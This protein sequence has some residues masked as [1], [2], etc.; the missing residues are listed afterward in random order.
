MKPPPR[1]F[2]FKVL[3]STFPNVTSKTPDDVPLEQVLTD[4]RNG[5]HAEQVASAREIYRKEGKS[6][7]YSAAKKSLPAFAMSGTIARGEKATRVHSNVLQVDAD[8]LG[9]RLADLRERIEADPHVLFVF[10][11][12]SGD[13]LKIGLRVD[14]SL[15][16]E[17]WQAAADYFAATYSLK[18][19]PA[20]KNPRS[21]CFVSHDP[22]LTWRKLAYLFPLPKGDSPKG[23]VSKRE[24]TKGNPPL[25]MLRLGGVGGVGGVGA[26]SAEISDA[27]KGQIDQAVEIGAQTKSN[28]DA[29]FQAAIALVRLRHAEDLSDLTTPERN[30]FKLRWYQRLR[31]LGRIT[32]GKAQTHYFDNI[33]N[34]IKKVKA[35]D[36]TKNPVPQAWLLAQN[37]PLPPEAAMFDGDET[38]QRLIALCYQLHVLSSGGEWFVARNTVGELMGL[39]ETGTRNLSENFHVLVDC[40]ILVV[41][42][43]YEK[44]KRKA[45]IYRYVAQGKPT[46]E[47]PE[48]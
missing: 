2:D 15:H 24:A 34:A 40:G 16:A 29:C 23:D 8:E 10:L 1:P 38:M 9:E 45:T 20:P 21:L 25:S 33:A 26:P 13:G 36:R 5:T 17:S 43:P 12:P 11:S 31:S 28:N 32:A 6:G 37:S 4:I 14:G 18:I 27:V 44:G 35:S 22:A 7:R 48:L 46:Q 3:V 19:D 39:D 30:Y 41:V 42:K 47:P